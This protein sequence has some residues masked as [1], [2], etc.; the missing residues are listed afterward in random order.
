MKRFETIKENIGKI[1]V[2]IKSGVCFEKIVVDIYCKINDGE[3]IEVRR[4]DE[5]QGA[6]VFEFSEIINKKK[7]SGLKLENYAEIKKAYEEMKLSAKTQNEAAV[8]QETEEIISGKKKIVVKYH[9]G[10]Y[11]SGYRISE[12][13]VFSKQIVTELLGKIGICDDNGYI[14]RAAIDALGEEFTYNDALEYVNPALKEKKAK[15]ESKKIELNAK[16]VA[17]LETGKPVLIRKWF[18]DCCDDN[19]DCDVDVHYEYA[20]PD[21]TTKHEWSHTW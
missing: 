5:K 2:F 1:G 16:F 14:G 17:A 7:T 10:E 20:M 8:T 15:E 4:F 3:R 19:E 18:S 9:D 6:I 13:T 11:F 21:G 12:K